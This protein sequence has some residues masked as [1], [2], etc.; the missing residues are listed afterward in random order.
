MRPPARLDYLA[1]HQ[2]EFDWMSARELE[3]NR[4]ITFLD[5]DESYNPFYYRQTPARSSDQ[6]PPL[7]AR[8]VGEGQHEFDRR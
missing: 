6:D 7:L 4:D 3:T 5:E 8:D 1:S 2:Q